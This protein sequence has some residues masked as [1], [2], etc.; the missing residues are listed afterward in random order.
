MYS[1][2]LV[3]VT[4]GTIICSDNAPNL[5]I[6]SDALLEILKARPDGF[7]KEAGKLM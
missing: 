1:K 7:T 4:K 6:R 2:K 3:S 5:L